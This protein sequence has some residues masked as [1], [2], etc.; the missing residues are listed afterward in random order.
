MIGRINE[1]I[2]TILD[3]E[4][5]FV[6]GRL[7]DTLKSYLKD[8]AKQDTRTISDREIRSLVTELVDMYVN[9]VMTLEDVNDNIITEVFS[10]VQ[11]NRAEVTLSIWERRS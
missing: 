4:G 3:E 6:N 1:T 5:I 8:T 2:M 9:D 10:R 7:S 11:I